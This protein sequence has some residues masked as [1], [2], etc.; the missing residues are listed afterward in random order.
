MQYLCEREDQIDSYCELIIDSY[1]LNYNN[2]IELISLDTRIVNIFKIINNEKKYHID[3]KYDIHKCYKIIKNILNLYDVD[4]NEILR[5]LGY[6]NQLKLLSKFSFFCLKNKVKIYT[7]ISNYFAKYKLIDLTLNEF[8]Y[9]MFVHNFDFFYNTG[10]KITEKYFFDSLLFMLKYN[11]RYY[12]I[13]S[14][15]DWEDINNIFLYR[16]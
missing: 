1:N 8:S 7:P 14:S 6:N 3:N 2:F 10:I 15:V 12:G 11:Y 9:L 4:S 5:N 16:N 13:K